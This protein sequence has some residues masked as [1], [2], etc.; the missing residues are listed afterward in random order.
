[1]GIG[2]FNVAVTNSTRA[3][4]TEAQDVEDTIIKIRNDRHTLLK[5]NSIAK[6]PERIKELASQHQMTIDTNVITLPVAAGFTPEV[7]AALE[8]KRVK[9]QEALTKPVAPAVAPAAFTV[10][11]AVVENAL[12]AATGQLDATT[13]VAHQ[14]ESGGD[15]Q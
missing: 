6:R 5:D 13:A 15:G 10:P 2:V 1:M 7:Q 9:R 4:M 8:E 14:A 3:L 11:G 12:Q